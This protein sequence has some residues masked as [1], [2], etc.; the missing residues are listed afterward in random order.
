MRIPAWRRFAPFVT[1]LA[2]AIAFLVPAPVLAQSAPAAPPADAP[3]APGDALPAGDKPAGEAP[4]AAAPEKPADPEQAKKDKAKEHFLKGLQLAQTEDWDAAL[5]EFLTSRDIYPTKSALLNAA[6][7]LRNLK[8]HADAYAMYEE[9]LQNFSAQLEPDQKKSVEDAMAQL[10]GLVARIDVKSDQPTSIVVIDGQERGTTPLPKPVLV[11]AGTHSIRVFKEGFLPYETQVLIAAGQVKTVDAQLKALVKSGRLRV[12]EAD[13]RTM[14]VLVDG[15]VVGK[16]PWEGTLGVGTHTVILRGEGNVGTPPSS[17]TV[18]NGQLSQLSLRATTLDAQLRVEPTPSNARVDIDGVTVGN[19]IWDGRLKSGAHKVEVTAEG[20]LAF[21]K[22]IV[23]ASGKAEVV[24]VSLERNPDDPRWT[25]FRPHV[26]AELVGGLALSPSFGGSADDSCGS[27]KCSERSRPFGFIVGARGGYQATSGL[28]IELFVGYLKLKESMTRDGKS[29]VA[30]PHVVSLTSAAYEDT[31]NIAGP[32]AALSASYQLF[33]TTPLTFRLWAGAARVKATFTNSGSFAGR[34]RNPADPN[35]IADFTLD[36]S[37]PEKSTQLWIPMVGPEARIG[38]RI[39]RRFMVD[40]GM[41]AFFMFGPETP[42][43][44]A[45]GGERTQSFDGSPGRYASGDPI[46]V[47]GIVQLDP[48]KGFGT[49]VMLVP[50]L[51]AR[52]DF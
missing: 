10:Q 35:E 46:P 33:E 4:P 18:F 45:A 36:V 8:R 6:V 32:M 43:E 5:A 21:R 14:E 27:G 11:S 40:L 49:F 22:D 39:S 17:A 1:L 7:A 29:A 50:S 3:K 51:A 48:D 9:L 28:G 26:Y 38:Y 37:V 19:G 31:T 41:A 2:L 23:I 25:Q 13:G 30:D 42:R 15:A 44:G 24:N 12:A 47:P 34:S 52:Y 20:F 16:T